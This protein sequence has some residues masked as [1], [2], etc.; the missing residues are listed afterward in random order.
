MEIQ[1]LLTLPTETARE[2]LETMPTRRRVSR[3]AR[4]GVENDGVRSAND[5]RLEQFC[6]VAKS[7]EIQA[8]VHLRLPP[9]QDI[10]APG[11]FVLVV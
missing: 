2:L 9:L 7:R 11:V 6:I 3:I 1:L 4:A 5:I 8:R 10:N